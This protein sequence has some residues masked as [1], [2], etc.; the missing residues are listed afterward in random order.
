MAYGK[1]AVRAVL[2]EYLGSFAVVQ[3][4]DA[5]AVRSYLDGP[6]AFWIAEDDSA[7]VGCVAFRPLPGR[8]AAAGEVKRLYV[9]SDRRGG[10]LAMALMGALEDW[11][12]RAGYSTLYLDTR[13]D[14]PAAARLYE[15][16]GYLHVPRY[17]DNPEAAV[18]MRLRLPRIVP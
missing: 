17:N 7:V 5:A 11:A 8:G 10:G 1:A 12:Q 4:D 2:E 6:G 14:M 13:T 18:F 3:V 9:R 16:R 15:R